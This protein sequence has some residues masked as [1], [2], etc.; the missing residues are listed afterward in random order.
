MGGTSCSRIPLAQKPSYSGSIPRF[1][2]TGDICEQRDA[3]FETQVTPASP[4]PEV[5]Q[6][7]DVC[8]KR[9]TLGEGVS[10]VA[11]ATT[12]GEGERG[13]GEIPVVAVQQGHLDPV[14]KGHIGL[15]P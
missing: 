6:E 9:R 5:R 8:P 4:Q 12:P 10:E 11:R 15:C 2:S 14:R 1:L 3:R 7:S 13:I